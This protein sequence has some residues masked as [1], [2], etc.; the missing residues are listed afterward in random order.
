MICQVVQTPIWMT[1]AYPGDKC[2]ATAL[3]VGAGSTCDK[4]VCTGMALD[5]T[6]ADSTA[7]NPGFYCN[8]ATTKCAAQIKVNTMGCLLDTDC[9]NGASCDMVSTTVAASNTCK[10]TMMMA[11]GTVISPNACTLTGT[12]TLCMS[13]MCK[14]ATTGANAGSTVCVAFVTTPGSK[15]P[16]QCYMDPND[17]MSTTD[18]ITGYSTKSA[19]TCTE[20]SNPKLYCGLFM[21]DKP[22]Q[23]A[24]SSLMSWMMSSTINK[25]NTVEARSS[26]NLCQYNNWSS[27]KFEDWLYYSL[28]ASNYPNLQGSSSCVYKALHWDYAKYKSD[29]G[30]GLLAVSAFV[31]ALF[32]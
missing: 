7:C 3:C 14:V 21:G 4:G 18:A 24:M 29:S 19:C 16:A 26:P 27:S 11:G 13:G 6:C 15:I 8:L 22:Y 32:A 9:V 31:I 10:M 1:R 12:S 23:K 25:C 30:A 5:G 20:T 28:Y 17:C 2:T